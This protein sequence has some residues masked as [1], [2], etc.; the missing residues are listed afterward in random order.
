MPN[1]DEYQKS[2]QKT[3]DTVLSWNIITHR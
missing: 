1:D 2:V 3:S